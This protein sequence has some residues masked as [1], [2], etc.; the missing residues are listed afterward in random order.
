MK[1]TMN[2]ILATAVALFLFSCTSPLGLDDV[3]ITSD[4]NVYFPLNTGNYW[5]YQYTAYEKTYIDSMVYTG[6]EYVDGKNAYEITTYRNG[7]EVA[8]TYYLTDDSKI[9]MHAMILEPLLDTMFCGCTFHW[10]LRWRQIANFTKSWN[11]TD[12]ITGDTYPSLVDNGQGGYNTIY[13]RTYHKLDLIG[14]SGTYEYI[15]INT[16]TV[17]TYT[18]LFKGTWYY[19][20]DT[21]NNS[22]RFKTDSSARRV[23]DYTMIFEDMQLHLWFS[24]N[25][26]IVKT[27]GVIH[28][29]EN[30]PYYYSRKLLR[31]H[32]N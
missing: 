24:Q 22:V 2:L 8:R 6:M 23:N 27:E 18:Y 16:D 7:Y 9:F 12:T 17:Q 26:G 30:K 13:S 4:A 11:K 1:T 29:Y 28:D 19:I 20:L 31:Y 10:P 15:P 5:V 21:T 25:I 3:R 14:N 32:I